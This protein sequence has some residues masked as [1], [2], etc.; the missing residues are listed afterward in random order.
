LR[1][2]CPSNPSSRRSATSG[3]AC[4]LACAVFFKS[5]PATREAFP[6]DRAR[7]RHAAFHREPFEQF[8]DRQVRRLVDKRE[9]VVPVGIGLA[10]LGPALLAGGPVS[11]FARAPDPNNRRGD[12]YAVLRRRSP[13]R[14]ARK[15]GGYNAISQILAVGPSPGAS[16]SQSRARTRTSPPE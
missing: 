11:A 2:S 14:F 16:P 1:S 15:R 4:S 12:P 5:Q 6:Q 8:A 10:T 13:D 9:Q 3:R 7:N